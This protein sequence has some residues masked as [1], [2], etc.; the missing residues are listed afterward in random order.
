MLSLVPHRFPSWVSHSYLKRFYQLQIENKEGILIGQLPLKYFCILPQ[1]ASQGDS[2]WSQSPSSLPPHQIHHPA[3]SL[4]FLLKGGGI[5]GRRVE[6]WA[7]VK[8]LKLQGRKKKRGLHQL[9]PKKALP[10]SRTT[11]CFVLSKVDLLC[12]E[13]ALA[14]HI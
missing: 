6:G 1:T 5:P 8:D 7:L 12:K 9:N 14:N 4:A 10:Q 3:A 11:I 2:A 13:I